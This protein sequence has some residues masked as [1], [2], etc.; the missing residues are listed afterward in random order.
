MLDDIWKLGNGWSSDCE[1]DSGD[2]PIF[3]KLLLVFNGK[4]KDVISMFG[5]T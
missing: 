2:S 4:M 3:Q 1:R 5:R